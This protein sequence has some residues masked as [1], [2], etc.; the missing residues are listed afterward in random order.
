MQNNKII[1]A[2]LYMKNK[3]SKPISSI[4]WVCQYFHHWWYIKMD[5][6]AAPEEGSQNI[7][8]TPCWLA[9]VQVINPI[10]SM[11]ADGTRAFFGTSY[12][13]DVCSSVFNYFGLFVLWGV[14]TSWLTAESCLWLSQAGVCAG[15]QTPGHN[16][17]RLWLQMMSPTKIAGLIFR[18]FRFHCCTVA[19]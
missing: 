16:C 2:V 17:C 3:D 19:C 5:N 18:I 6:M 13:A 12:L 11:L 9:A 10:L 4:T 15:I 1:R 8:I 14:E 7:W